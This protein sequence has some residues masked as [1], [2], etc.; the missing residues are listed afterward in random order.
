M[1]RMAVALVFA[2]LV[3]TLG[4]HLEETDEVSFLQSEVV[5]RKRGKVK[6][7]VD[8]DE[9]STQEKESSCQAFS[10]DVLENSASSEKEGTFVDAG[11]VAVEEPAMLEAVSTSED[12][13]VETRAAS[14]A[15]GYLLDIFIIAIFWDGLRRWNAKQKTEAKSAT[16]ASPISASTPKADAD[17][18]NLMSAALA[19]NLSQC[20]TLIRKG[21]SIGK[22]D[23]WGCTVLHAAAK[24]GCAALVKKLLEKRAGGIDR[25][26]AWDETPLH[27]AARAGHM[28]VCEVLLA[29]G[30]RINIVNAQD[31][32][33]LVVAA[34]ANQEDVCNLLMSRGAIAEGLEGDLP[35]LLTKLL[36]RRVFE[37]DE[38]A[39]AG[40]DM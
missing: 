7:A 2:V 32:T 33:A 37:H 21:V 27:I 12:Q 34:D 31:W 13:A 22:A 9:R 26:D 30:A 17:W 5:T 25:P 23:V 14:S 38:T 3:G 20:E 24:G 40:F 39:D 6:P 15:L 29:H 8:E 36:A 4:Q 10:A 28:E 18:D 35:T 1:A 11:I 16:N 19:G